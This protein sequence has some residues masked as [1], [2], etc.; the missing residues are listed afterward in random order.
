MQL[1]VAHNAD[2][3]RAGRWFDNEAELLVVALAL[4]DHSSGQW[5]ALNA[6]DQPLRLS[7]YA[8]AAAVLIVVVI[9]TIPI[10]VVVKS[11]GCSLLF[12]KEEAGHLEFA[13]EETG[14]IVSGF[15]ES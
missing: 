14:K 10:C 5:H 7:L 1:L 11:V 8:F 13:G 2:L 15:V 12:A 9:S 3:A 6:L 4:G